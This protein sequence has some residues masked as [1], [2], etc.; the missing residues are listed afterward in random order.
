MISS[1]DADF[2]CNCYTLKISQTCEKNGLVGYLTLARDRIQ[3]DAT[4]VIKPSQPTL[5]SVAILPLGITKL[6][7]AKVYQSLKK[8]NEGQGDGEQRGGAVET[9]SFN[10]ASLRAVLPITDDES[11]PFYLVKA[12]SGHKSAAVASVTPKRGG[13]FGLKGD[14]LG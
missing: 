7:I 6:F 5:T 1:L 10:Y 12:Y 2:F 3:S 9:A 11:V 8:E 13:Q 4:R 14:T